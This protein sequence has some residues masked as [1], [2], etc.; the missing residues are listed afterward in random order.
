MHV[1]RFEVDFGRLS[2]KERQLMFLPTTSAVLAY[3]EMNMG[4]MAIAAAELVIQN[5]GSATPDDVLTCWCL[6]GGVIG[7][8]CSLH[9][10]RP[11]SRFAAGAQFG[12]NVGL[13]SMFSPFLVDVV[14]YFTKFPPN[15]RLAMPISAFVGIVAC[16]AVAKLL[17]I[18]QD[19]FEK[20][21]NTFRDKL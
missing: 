2:V 10:Y 20:K 21:L 11:P 17:P 8:F 18:V 16:S 13:S 14:S 9:F 3:L 15:V 4:V 6:L 7:S 1:L 5:G 12:V 19:I